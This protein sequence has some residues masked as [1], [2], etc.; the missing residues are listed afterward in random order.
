MMRLYWTTHRVEGELSSI[1]LDAAERG[2]EVP[3]WATDALRRLRVSQGSRSMLRELGALAAP[4][5]SARAMMRVRRAVMR[6][7]R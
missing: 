4:R 1:L 2:D 5:R 7:G 6:R 3:P